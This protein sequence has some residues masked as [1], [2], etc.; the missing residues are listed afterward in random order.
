LYAG[1]GSLLLWLRDPGALE[2]ASRLHRDNLIQAAA[3]HACP[4]VD[5]GPN[6]PD[7]LLLLL[8]AGLGEAR[9]RRVRRPAPR[10]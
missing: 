6:G 9:A 1:E 2:S 4:Q 7:D 10:A 5:C 3:T 8:G